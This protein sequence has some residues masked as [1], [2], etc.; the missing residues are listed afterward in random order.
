MSLPSSPTTW[1]A[2]EAFGALYGLPRNPLY[3]QKHFQ[4]DQRIWGLDFSWHELSW[5]HPHNPFS[6]AT[7]WI[8]KRVSYLQATES[9]H[10]PKLNSR[11]TDNFGDLLALEFSGNDCNT[12]TVVINYLQSTLLSTS[13]HVQI[14][15]RMQYLFEPAWLNIHKPL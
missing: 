6:T 9:V 12:Q 3:I 13:D 2:Q 11:A 4:W 14:M 15:K 10:I 8:P 1:S 5:L 7:G